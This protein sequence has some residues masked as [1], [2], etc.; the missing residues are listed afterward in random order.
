[1]TMD[2]RVE[3]RLEDFAP[4][5][6]ER[7]EDYAPCW[8]D[9]RPEDYAD[10]AVEERDED[11]APWD[12]ERLEDYAVD[13]VQESD[14]GAPEVPKLKSSAL[15]DKEVVHLYDALSFALWQFGP[16]AIMT[17]HIVILWRTLGVTEHT[18]ARHLLGQYLN[19]CQKWGQ[20]ASQR[21]W[22]ADGVCNGPCGSPD[23][24][25]AS[26]SDMSSRMSAAETRAF[27]VMF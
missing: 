12:E 15:S 26:I 21:L 4:W 10:C 14:K 3:I 9:D 2:D 6:E 23:T 22:T 5:A 24:V 13:F 17:V 16:S 19:R 7:D 20:L 11:Y 8:V 18:Q 1:M 27:T 25:T